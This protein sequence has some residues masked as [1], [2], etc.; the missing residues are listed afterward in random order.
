MEAEVHPES[1]DYAAIYNK[2]HGIR[3]EHAKP[4]TFLG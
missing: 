1:L 3:L 4:A 2:A